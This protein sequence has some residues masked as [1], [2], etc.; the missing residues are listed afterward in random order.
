[1]VGHEVVVVNRLYG[2]GQRIPHFGM[3]VALDVTA[4]YPHYV[5]AVL[6]AVGQE[7]TVGLCLL[8]VHPPRLYHAAPDADHAHEDAA[9]AGL[10]ND[11]VHVVPITVDSRAVDAVEVEPV[12]HR[13]LSIGVK[14]RYAIYHLHLHDIVT[15]SSQTVEI[16]GCLVAVEPLGHQPARVA[17]PEE[18]PA[19]GILQETSALRHF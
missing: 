6:I 3:Y 1:M 16:I 9:A 2:S 4:H 7:T 17:E 18:G 11:I 10:V 19:V 5:L 13:H 8:Y 14:G 12:G 15:G